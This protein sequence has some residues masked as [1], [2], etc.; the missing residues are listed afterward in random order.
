MIEPVGFN[1]NAETGVDNAFQCA[2]AGGGDAVAQAARQEMLRLKDALTAAGVTVTSFLGQADC[3]DDVFP[4]NWLSTS[5]D[6]GLYLYPMATP[7]RRKERR[8]DIIE[9]LR[10]AYDYLFDL[11]QAERSEKI[12]ESTGALVLDNVHKVAYVGRSHRTDDD[13]IALW[14]RIAGYETVIFDTC[15]TV[16]GKPIYHTNV[17]CHIGTDYAALAPDMIVLADRARVMDA[18]GRHHELIMLEAAQVHHYC[19]NALEV[20]GG[21]GKRHLVLSAEARGALTAAQVAQYE[22]HIAGFISSP[23][24]TI[25]NYGGGSARCMVCEVF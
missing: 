2:G 4:N 3:P 20:V 8:A 1:Y 15:D 17:F 7:S 19:G 6:G 13:L 21:D 22:N 5:Q 9:R 16:T 23:V 11:T 14:G 25:E 18:L 12:L 10:P 24:P